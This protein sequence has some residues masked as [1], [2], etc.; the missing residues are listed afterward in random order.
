MIDNQ[1]VTQNPG[2]EA[3]ERL[4]FRF[5]PSA[6]PVID[7]IPFGKIGLQI[8]GE[9]KTLPKDSEIGRNEDCSGVPVFDSK[10]DMEQSNRDA[11]KRK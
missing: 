3:P 1:V 6:K 8:E 10:T 2:L 4:D 11:V 9:R 7:P 5:R